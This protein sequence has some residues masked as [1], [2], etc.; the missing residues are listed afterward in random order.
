[1]FTSDEILDMAIQI[2]LNGEGVYRQAVEKLA[3]PNLAAL[4]E[5]MADEEFRHA[6]WFEELKKRAAT[7]PD[8]PFIK[9]MSR[10]LFKDLLGEK[11]FSLREV[12]FESVEA[13]DELVAIF[14]EFEKD[15]ILFYQIIEPFIAEDTTL[16][17]L[18]KIIDEEHSH[19]AKLKK[20]IESEADLTVI[21]GPCERFLR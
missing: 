9:E 2:E 20:F 15:T 4:L 7:T 16:E 14:I 10:E 1:M 8:N 19:I 5:S 6:Q 21:D 12:D 11:G 13:V 17:T 18:K 3:K